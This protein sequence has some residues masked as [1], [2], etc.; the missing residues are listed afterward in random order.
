METALILTDADSPGVGE[1]VN[2]TAIIADNRCR[3]LEVA[4]FLVNFV[5]VD[6]LLCSNKEPRTNLI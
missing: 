6:T 3:M 2:S 4:L 1:H 5:L